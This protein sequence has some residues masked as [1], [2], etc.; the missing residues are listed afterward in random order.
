MEY[1]KGP[2]KLDRRSENLVGEDGKRVGI[3]GSGLTMCGLPD[4]E[5]VANT[6]LIAA[7][8]ELLEALKG[9]VEEWDELILNQSNYGYEKAIKAIAKAEGK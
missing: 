6:R 4:P 9:M 3:Y 8:P 1:T 2:W 7:A 5:S